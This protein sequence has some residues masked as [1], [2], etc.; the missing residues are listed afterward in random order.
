MSRDVLEYLF[1]NKY[2]DRDKKLREN[3]YQNSLKNWPN[4]LQGMPWSTDVW[5]N[6]YGADEHP[7]IGFMGVK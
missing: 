3:R 6:L 5:E 7:E 4:Q 1:E 2:V